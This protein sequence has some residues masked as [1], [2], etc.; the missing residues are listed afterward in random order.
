M[1]GCEG[2]D[3]SIE[4]EGIS[5]TYTYPCYFQ[6][7]LFLHYIWPL[8]NS[9]LIDSGEFSLQLGGCFD[10]GEVWMLFIDFVG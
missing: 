7:L 9:A 3:N 6:S 8:M 5:L 2:F 1:L 4:M 10:V